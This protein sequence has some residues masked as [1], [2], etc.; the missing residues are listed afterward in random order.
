MPD[1]RLPDKSITKHGWSSTC[2]SAPSEARKRGSGGGSPRKSDN[3]PAGPNLLT[4]LH[5]ILAMAVK[6]LVVRYK[7]RSEGRTPSEYQSSWF[8]GDPPPDPRF[9]ASLGALSLFGLAN[10]VEEGLREGFPPVIV[11]PGGS[12][13]RPPV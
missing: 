12:S 10:R 13:P 6:F 7:K 3:P 11:F 2:D 8:Q 1:P 4:T 9:L 5:F